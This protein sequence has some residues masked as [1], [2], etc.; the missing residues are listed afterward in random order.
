MDVAFDSVLQAALA[1]PL[2]KR[3][4]LIDSLAATL[5]SPIVPPLHPAWQAEIERRSAEFDAGL[6]QGRSWEEVKA[7]ARRRLSSDA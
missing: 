2:D 4:Q 1:L 3:E 7:Q 5:P 6:V